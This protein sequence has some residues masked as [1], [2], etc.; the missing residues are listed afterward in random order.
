MPAI[1]RVILYVKDIPKVAEFYQR[2]F[3]LKPLPSSEKGWLELA[4]EAGGCALALHQAASSQKSG[5][6]IKIV[7]GVADVMKFKQERE[8]DGLKFG[9]VHQPGD[10]EFANTTDPAGN[11]IQISSRGLTRNDAS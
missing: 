11:S 9:P 1:A 4:S 2:H 8:A 3:G 10:F 6:A 5:V 7:F